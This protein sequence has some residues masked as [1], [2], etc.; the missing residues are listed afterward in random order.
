MNTVVISSTSNG[1]VAGALAGRAGS[2]HATVR[3]LA[4]PG[5]VSSPRRTSARTA[6]ASGARGF[7]TI[8]QQGHEGW[9]LR[10]VLG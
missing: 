3:R 10:S 6:A 8:V 9:R 7:L 5:L 2:V 1:I 4:R